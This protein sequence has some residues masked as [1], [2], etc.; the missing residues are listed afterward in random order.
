M[1]IYARF[2]WSRPCRVFDF[3][4]VAAARP[5]TGFVFSVGTAIAAPGQKSTGYL[6]VPAS[7]DAAINIPV[8]VIKA[9]VLPHMHN[10]A[11]ARV[12]ALLFGAPA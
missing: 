11:A 3:S 6:E 2:L 9:H 12:E 8:V 7:V 4:A 1:E 10:E 5:V